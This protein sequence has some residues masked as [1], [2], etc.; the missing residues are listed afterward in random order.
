M[1]ALLIIV[2]LFRSYDGHQILSVHSTDRIK[3]EVHNFFGSAKLRAKF[4]LI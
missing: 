2:D 1:F 4:S 3:R